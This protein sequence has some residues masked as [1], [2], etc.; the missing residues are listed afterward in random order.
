MRG[1][2]KE[3]GEKRRMYV[4]EFL[5][6][7]ILHSYISV[8]R[9]GWWWMGEGESDPPAKCH[10]FAFHDVKIFAQAKFLVAFLCEKKEA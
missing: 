5:S 10:N 4:A 8:W 2:K 3:R 1:V 7:A 9:M 6:T